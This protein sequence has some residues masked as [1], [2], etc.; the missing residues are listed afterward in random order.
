MR[1]GDITI[2]LLPC[3]LLM[4]V[5]ERK[6]RAEDSEPSPS[7]LT[8]FVRRVANWWGFIAV[9]PNLTGSPT[10]QTT[11]GRVIPQL[12]RSHYRIVSNSA[13]GE[14]WLVSRNSKIERR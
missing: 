8:V 14:V 10:N 6:T 11:N 13:L 4:L 9:N 2:I 1:G 7:A 5:E 12:N 3:P